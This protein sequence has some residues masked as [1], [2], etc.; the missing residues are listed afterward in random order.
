[1]GGSSFGAPIGDILLTFLF[2]ADP[3]VGEGAT[4]DV[5]PDKDPVIFDGEEEPKLC[6]FFKIFW[7]DW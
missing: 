7:V 2:E 3:E 4:G 6:D 5:L 1:M